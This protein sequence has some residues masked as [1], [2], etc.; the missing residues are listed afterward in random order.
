MINNLSQDII[1]YFLNW[2]KNHQSIPTGRQL[3]EQFA[4]S[5]KNT[6]NSPKR[7][8]L[9]LRAEY[10]GNP[11]EII[12]YD[13][14][15]LKW[16]KELDKNQFYVPR[17]LLEDIC[18]FHEIIHHLLIYPTLIFPKCYLRRIRN[19]KS[20]EQEIIVRDIVQNWLIRKYPDYHDK[21]N[22][23]SI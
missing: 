12:L 7:G 18:I 20:S 5:I 3:A 11:A 15:I 19:L 13:Y 2:L 9:T 23:I 14:T 16:K 4:I 1:N 8:H 21:I 17:E 10:I 6:A 22:L